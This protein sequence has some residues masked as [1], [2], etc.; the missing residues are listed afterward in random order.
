M[1][2][3]QQAEEDK[4]PGNPLGFGRSGGIK[5]VRVMGNYDEGDD[6]NDSCSDGGL[7]GTVDK[8]GKG[9]PLYGR[10]PRVILGDK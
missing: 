8:D 1:W 6:N 2:Y 10:E 9:V 7:A 5:L 4:A 3:S